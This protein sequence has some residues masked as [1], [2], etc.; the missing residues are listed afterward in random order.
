V[1]IELIAGKTI[2]EGKVRPALRIQ[3]VN[4]LIK[5][6]PVITATIGDIC[7]TDTTKGITDTCIQDCI[8][9]TTGICIPG[10]TIDIKD[11]YTPCVTTGSTGTETAGKLII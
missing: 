4:V 10:F 5:S 2:I 3:E 9:D 11:I 8:K 6:I 1:I 7:I